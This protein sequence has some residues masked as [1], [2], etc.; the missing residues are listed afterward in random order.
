MTNKRLIFLSMLVLF[1]LSI[2]M[3]SAADDMSGQIDDIS[4]DS[5]Q[6]VL[7]IG[8]NDLNDG[9]SEL[10]NDDDSGETDEPTDNGDI[11]VEN[12]TFD[13]IQ[14]A[15]VQASEND[16]ILLNGT[17]T[18]TGKNMIIGNKAV[19]IQG[20]EN[21]V[22]DANQ[23]K[24][25]F[26]IDAPNVIFKDICFKNFKF[27]DNE[28]A[29]IIT[30]N[31]ITVNNC[32]FIN[33]TGVI[34]AII[35]N[36]GICKITDS[37]FSN[38]ANAFG[39]IYLN[40][41]ELDISNSS[42]NGNKIN[43]NQLNY[44]R[45]D[46]GSLPSGLITA[47][48]SKLSLSNLNF[49]SNKMDGLSADQCNYSVVNSV[50]NNTANAIV[51]ADSNS[52]IKNSTFTKLKNGIILYCGKNT[53]DACNFINNTAVSVIF[54]GDYYSG[55]SF[56]ISNSK[57]INNTNK[58][59]PSAIHV[60]RCS[61]KIL[62]CTFKNNSKLT[63][64]GIIFLETKAL[65]TV[66]NG[67]KTQKFKNATVLDNSLKAYD[68]ITF[69]VKNSFTTSYK[70]GKLFTGKVIYGFNK[71]TMSYFEG[72]CYIVKGKKEYWKEFGSNIKID[73]SKYPVGT[74]KVTFAVSPDG[75]EDFVWRNIRAVV[76]VKITKAKTIVK[77]P[78]VTAKYKK[79]KYFKVTIKNKA[80]NKAAAKIKVKIKV[81]TGKKYKTYTVKT[82]N[83]GVA[84]INTKKLKRGKHKVVISSGNSNYII[85]KKSSIRIK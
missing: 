69:V 17:Y 48:K 14:N 8:S 10:L 15:I 59:G 77:A 40:K 6:D 24:T 78:K 57:F 62:N 28:T 25:R 56:T 85:S 52:S 39:A 37:K 51:S 44:D 75:S 32:S 41:A 49:Y 20:V 67:N 23:F 18:S 30:K 47:Y 68:Y 70:S 65:V 42:F 43:A 11:P 7:S 74:Y 72:I 16:T 55:G 38:N 61:A 60:D 36:G 66:T 13:A 33:N 19:T 5:S 84:K 9:N 50:F 35:A 76:T 34:T 29:I 27:D 2:G 31:G 45:D 3:V 54:D 71:K 12:K 58:N 64:K 83:K 80:S 1:I 53:V 4:M 26:R 22:L 73:F 46:D 81:Y 21:A 82:D 63:E 79:S